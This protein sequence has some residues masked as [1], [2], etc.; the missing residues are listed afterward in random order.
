MIPS[1]HRNHSHSTTRFLPRRERKF[2]THRRDLHASHRH[3]HRYQQQ[4][5]HPQYRVP[6]TKFLQLRRS[7]P[8]SPRISPPS[9]SLR[10][11]PLLQPQQLLLPLVTAVALRPRLLLLQE[12]R[13]V[14]QY[15]E[16]Q[17]ILA[18][19]VPALIVYA[20]ALPPRKL[21]P[22]QPRRSLRSSRMPIG[23]S[24]RAS[25]SKISLLL[26]NEQCRSSLSGFSK[27]LIKMP[28]PIHQYR[29]WLH[30][31]SQLSRSQL[32]SL[33]QRRVPCLLLSHLLHPFL[34]L[35]PHRPQYHRY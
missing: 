25:S 15:P 33:P 20:H 29:P 21:W 2:K 19:A 16:P 23:H 18:A 22:S 5:Q 14:R 11:Y 17:H 34:S 31:P 26:G 6:P 7:F 35:S 27:G 28:T 10:Q 9:Q 30:L 13:E 1:L 32:L 12:T 24:S 4:R 8:L 3:Q